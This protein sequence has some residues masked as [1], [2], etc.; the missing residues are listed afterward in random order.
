MAKEYKSESAKG[1]GALVHRKRAQAS[2]IPLLV[3]SNRIHLIPPALNATNMCEQLSTR[4][5]Q[6]TE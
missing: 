4:E 5:A 2:K 6:H 3:V 1:N